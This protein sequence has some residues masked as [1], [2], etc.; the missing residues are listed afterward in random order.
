LKIDFRPEDLNRIYRNEEAL[1]D[2]A[3]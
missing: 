3:A 2:C 1:S